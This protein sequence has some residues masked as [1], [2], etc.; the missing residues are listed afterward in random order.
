MSRQTSVLLAPSSWSPD[1]TD[2]LTDSDLF[3]A[4]SRLLSS[5]SADAN[6]FTLHAPLELMAR[7]RLLPLVSPSRRTAARRRIAHIAETWAET[8]ATAAAPASGSESTPIE[9][10]LD[11]LRSAL[12]DGD[13]DSADRAFVA[14]CA[15][16]TPAEIVGDLAGLVLGL[17]GGAAHGAIFLELL[18]QFR[19]TSGINPALMGRTVIGD[20]ARHPDWRLRWL[21]E[22][23]PAPSDASLF[24]RLTSPRAEGRPSSHFVQPTM[25]LVDDT[26]LAHRALADVTQHLT[27]DQARRELLPIAAMSMLQ[28]DPANAP[29]GWTHCLTLPAAAL[30]IGDR[31]DD[32]QRA[33]DVAATFVLGFRATQS[34]TAIDP[35]WAPEPPQRFIA[36]VERLHPG[37]A[38]A[39]TWHADTAMRASIVQRL[40]DHAATH[41][42][43]HLVKYTLAC[44][45]AAEHDPSN[46]HL[47]LAAAAFLAAWWNEHDL[48]EG[49]TT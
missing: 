45:D 7:A 32:P 49:A 17:L 8:A 42:D 2:R 44:L 14:L 4:A 25:A 20:I 18:P 22:P 29:Y 35:S 39:T 21:D 28:D 40:V 31:T 36:E 6:S 15:A 9:R 37:A 11:V 5:S 26:G 16:R 47:F 27:I 3:D 10:P 38:A 30:A 24:E 34:S 46:E 33:V 1:H 12:E 13:P 48:A 23:S 41:R 19:P 43:A